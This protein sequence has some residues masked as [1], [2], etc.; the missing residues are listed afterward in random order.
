M[1]IMILW[2]DNISIV[3]WKMLLIG[4]FFLMLNSGIF[5][6]M[7]YF[8]R[9][10]AIEYGYPKRNKKSLRKRLANHSI[11]DKL[12]LFRITREA[13]RKGA[14]LYINL[15]C[16]CLNMTALF[17]SCIGFVGCMLTCAEGWALTLL[18]ISEIGALFITVMIEFVPHLIW[19]PSEKRRYRLK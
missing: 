14:L 17:L 19:L 10:V 3:W 9:G 1:G 16:H 5:L 7:L 12:L 8:R 2:H 13:E 6:S 18:T 4:A 11:W 15:G